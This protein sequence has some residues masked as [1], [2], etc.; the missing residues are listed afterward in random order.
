MLL[1]N[2]SQTRVRHRLEMKGLKD[3]GKEGGRKEK[4]EIKDAERENNV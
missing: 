3:G 1:F 4:I 2:Q